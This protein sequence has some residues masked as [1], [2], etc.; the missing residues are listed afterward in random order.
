MTD[1]DAV[2]AF[3]SI[4]T[5]LNLGLLLR[6]WHQ[7]P[8]RI[9]PPD[10]MFPTGVQMNSFKGVSRRAG[11]IEIAA[12]QTAY[13]FVFLSK[14]CPKCRASAP[15]VMDVARNAAGHGVAIWVA[16]TDR[17]TAADLGQP[18]DFEAFFL[19]LSP[20]T[21]AMLNPRRASPAYLFV[22]SDMMA[23]ASGFI[24]DANWRSFADQLGEMA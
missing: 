3:L 5:T 6:L 18:E 8:N 11:P 14:G 7:M 15:A 10:L 13:A 1:R 12:G 23:Q 20:T 17:L 4:A 19:D 16:A 21:Y 2:L 24:G 9:D 22:S